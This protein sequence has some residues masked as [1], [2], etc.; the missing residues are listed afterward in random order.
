MFTTYDITVPDPAETRLEDFIISITIVLDVLFG[1][2]IF[3]IIA[4]KIAYFIIDTVNP[5]LN[6]YF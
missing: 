4:T 5:W 3:G 2:T 6:K 1:A